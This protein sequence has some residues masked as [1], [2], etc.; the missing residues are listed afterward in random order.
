VKFDIGDFGKVC[1][2]TPNLVKNPKTI[3]GTVHVDPSNFIPLAAVLSILYLGNNEKGGDCCIS[4]AIINTT[5]LLTVTF[6]SKI[7]LKSIFAFT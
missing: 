2:R 3:R 7:K 4:M 6:V 1:H 5:V